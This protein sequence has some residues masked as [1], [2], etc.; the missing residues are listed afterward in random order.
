ML[1][2][3]GKLLRLKKSFSSYLM[4]VSC[5]MLHVFRNEIIRS[6]LINLIKRMKYLAFWT[7]LLI[8]VIPKHIGY[9][10]EKTITISGNVAF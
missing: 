2:M 3:A 10:K 6:F 5:F 9:G 4:F 7:I 1:L 8:F